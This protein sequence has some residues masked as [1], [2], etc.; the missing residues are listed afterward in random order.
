MVTS[1]ADGSKISFEQAI[2]ANATGFKVQSRGM[3][4]GMEYKED[5]MKIGKL[6]DIDKARKLGGIVDYVVGT[7]L[8]KFYVLAE[9]PDP[10]QQH[11]LSLY[12]MG[13][14]PLYLV[15]PSRTTWSISKCRTRL[16]AWRCSAIP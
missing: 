14:G 15:L 2:V 13:D 7:P 6:Y 1:F 5:V 12:K 3:S 8:T 10:K 16:R 11:Y 9:H 4:R